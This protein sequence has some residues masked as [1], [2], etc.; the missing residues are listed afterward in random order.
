MPYPQFDRFRVRMESLSERV[1]KKYIERDHVSPTQAFEAFDS[2]AQQTVLQCAQRIRMARE[3]GRSVM[4]AFGAH[5]IKN[6]LAPVLSRLIEE[7]WVT[8]LATNGA[9]IIHDWEFAYCGASCEDVQSM[10]QDGRFGNWQETGYL[11]NLALNV[12][13][14]E[15]KGYGESVG[16]LIEN[17]GITIP[18]REELR[19]LIRDRL[20]D[21]PAECAAAADLLHLIETFDL[22]VGWM[23]LPHRWK[24]FSVQAQAFRLS[25][26]LTGHPMIGHDIIYNHPMNHCA[27]LGRAAERDFL[28]FAH[29]VSNLTGGVYLSIGSAVMSPMVFEKSLSIA[30]N[31]ALGQAERI[32]NFLILV[33]DLAKSDW[34]WSQG[35]PPEQ[36]PAYYL[37]YNKSFSRMGGTMRYLQADNRHFSLALLKSLQ[38][39]GAAPSED[40]HFV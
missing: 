20:A 29:G 4:M 12:G 34:D 21:A 33:V 27:S 16:A 6:G 36:D 14:F 2:N 11:I 3:N 17:E 22:P 19:Q 40:D 23:A 13:A 8:H 26:P 9:G 15:G 39:E 32:D 1:H 5:A 28:T 30:Q 18:G 38:T 35:E 31:V 37:R 7:G 10:V 24:E 25:V